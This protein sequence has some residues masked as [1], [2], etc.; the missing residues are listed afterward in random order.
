MKKKL[1]GVVRK[2]LA[3]FMRVSSF[4]LP[5]TTA[6]PLDRIRLYTKLGLALYGRELGLVE[7]TPEQELA[8]LGYY[9]RIRLNGDLFSRLLR[10]EG[11]V[12][13]VDPEQLWTCQAV[14]LQRGK[15]KF[16]GTGSKT[17]SM[18]DYEDGDPQ[19]TFTRLFFKDEHDAEQLILTLWAELGDE[20]RVGRGLMGRVEITWD[21]VKEQVVLWNGSTR[22]DRLSREFSEMVSARG[23]CS[24]MLYGPPGTGKSLIATTIA[25]KTGRRIARIDASSVDRTTGLGALIEFL[26]LMRIEVVV[27]DEVDK[28][29]DLGL[30]LLDFVSHLHSRGISSIFTANQVERFNEGLFRPGRIAIWERFTAPDEAERATILQVEGD[31]PLVA[32]SEGLTQDYLLDI[33][34]R[35]STLSA[36][37]LLAYVRSKKTLLE[38]AS[39]TE[40]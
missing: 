4:S 9:H 40:A 28:I 2:S 39:S 34:A 32:A 14:F 20:M 29:R 5:T 8:Q 7:D 33:V 1:L 37:A 15:L 13:G 10:N 12:S 19:L 38:Q 17:F 27:V 36:E 30:T 23:S 18:R 31:H 3:V 35:K 6:H 16:V 11:W 24:A 21:T 22:L 25:H 26:S